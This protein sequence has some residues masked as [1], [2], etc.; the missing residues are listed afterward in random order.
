MPKNIT[1]K[2]KGGYKNDISNNDKI[3]R[4]KTKFD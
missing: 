4:R 2:T 3:N 1:D